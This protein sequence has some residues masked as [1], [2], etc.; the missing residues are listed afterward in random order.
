MAIKHKRTSTASYTWQSS[1][2]AEGQIGLNIADGTLHFK[3]TDN[4]VVTIAESTGGGI[5]SLSQDPSPTLGGSLDIGNYFIQSTTGGVTLIPASGETIDLAA[6]V[7]VGEQNTNATITTDGT[8]DLILNTDGGLN[9]GSIVIAD[10]ANADISITP[11][12]TGKISLD[13]QLWPNTLGSNGQ[14]L[15]TNGSG[16]LSWI[17]AGGGVTMALVSGATSFYTGTKYINWTTEDYDPAG[18]VT[19]SNGTF[20]IGSAGTYLIHWTTSHGM[21]DPNSWRLYNVTGSAILKSFSLAAFGGGTSNG[22]AGGWSYVHTIT[23][24]NVY[25]WECP[26]TAA[27]SITNTP[28]MQIIKL[29]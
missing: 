22:L 15:S 3:K 10:G 6:D 13:G 12:G 20:T 29:A 18:L 28:Q 23:G 2:L 9:S 1:D 11:N 8:S 17:N 25:R 14:V 27:S 16:V 7:I 24:S 5:S 26:N 21:G 4:S 19:V